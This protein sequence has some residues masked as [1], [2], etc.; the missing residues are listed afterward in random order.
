MYQDSV[1]GL[2]KG[3]LESS[4]L[5]ELVEAVV[6]ANVLLSE[7]DV[8]NSPLAGVLEQSSLH[9]RT[10]GD[11]V[12]LDGRVL[13]TSGVEEAFGALAVGAV[14]LGEDCDVVGAQLLGDELVRVEEHFLARLTLLVHA[15]TLAEAGLLLA[16]VERVGLARLGLLGKAVILAG[17]AL[18][19]RHGKHHN[20]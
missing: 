2:G 16:P 19:Q 14:G 15:H 6:A 4:L 17:N 1:L 20:Q 18:Y 7:E 10:V 3:R 5:L 8:G 11:D 12:H 9:I 13:D